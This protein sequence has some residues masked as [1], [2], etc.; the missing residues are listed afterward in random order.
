MEQLFG[1]EIQLVILGT[2]E[3]KYEAL[4]TKLCHAYP[5]QLGVRIGFDES[6]A[7]KIEGG[8]DLFLMPSKFE[9][10]GLNQMY[11]LRYGTIPVVRATGGL[12]DTIQT[13]D[14]VSKTGN[15]FKFHD[16]SPTALL[17]AVETSTAFY[18]DHSLWRQLMVNAMLGDFSW[19]NSVTEYVALYRKLI[20]PQSLS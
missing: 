7:H 6:I 4:L 11:S 2:G 9:P 15:G 8:A 14:P 13:F 18:R 5:R 16:Y 19:E 20:A 3:P 10:C 1:L 12:D 17:E